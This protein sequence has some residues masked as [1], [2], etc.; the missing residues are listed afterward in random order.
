VVEQADGESISEEGSRKVIHERSVG[1][2]HL[3]VPGPRGKSVQAN[4]KRSC[5]HEGLENN[6]YPYTG[7]NRAKYQVGC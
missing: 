6:K 4:V 1:D 7:G 5:R 3:A 2:R